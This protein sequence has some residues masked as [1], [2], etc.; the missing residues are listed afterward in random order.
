MYRK[1]AARSPPIDRARAVRLLP[2]ILRPLSFLRGREFGGSVVGGLRGAQRSNTRHD[3]KTPHKK[4]HPSSNPQVLLFFIFSLLTLKRCSLSVF[5]LSLS[6]FSELFP[7]TY[8]I[9]KFITCKGFLGKE[10]GKKQEGGLLLVAYKEPTE[11][12]SL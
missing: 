1:S 4:T 11:G 2:Y 6:L 5:S 9:S 12:S 10:E 3:P 8:S 7:L